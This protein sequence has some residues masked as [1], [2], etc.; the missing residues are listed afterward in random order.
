MKSLFDK[1]PAAPTLF[2]IG[3][4]YLLGLIGFRGVDRA[5]VEL[6][7]RVRTA[8]DHLM[9]GA[10]GELFASPH[11]L[12]DVLGIPLAALGSLELWGFGIVASIAVALCLPAVWKMARAVSGRLGAIFAV[13]FF[14]G[15]P[16]VTAAA[17]TVGESAI[18]LVLWCWLLRFSVRS[19][20]TRLST[21]LLVGLAVALT[22]SWAPALLWLVVWLV[23]YIAARGFSHPE[24]RVDAEGLIDP[25]TIPL[26]LILAPLAAVVVPSLLFL[27]ADGD[28]GAGWTRFLEHA[29]F[30]DWAVIEY[31]GEVFEEGRP[32]LLIGVSWLAFET[33]PV[34][35][36]TAMA[37]LILPATERFGLFVERPDRTR[38]FEFP[39]SLCVA[40][41]IFLLLLP[42]ALRTRSIGGVQTLLLAAPILAILAGALAATIVRSVADYVEAHDFSAPIR[43]TTLG[44]LTGLLLAPGLVE[45][46][47]VHPYEGSYYNLFSNSIA[48]AVDHGHP[49]IRDDAL[50]RSV[51]RE[52]AD[53]AGDRALYTDR[54]RDH[55]ETYLHTDHLTLTHLAESPDEADAHFYARGAEPDVD[56]D[57]RFTWGMEGVALYYLDLNGVE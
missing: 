35:L 20:H 10:I 28:I 50:P 8:N 41:L 37:A 30:G 11:P 48:G 46:V 18:V 9:E 14:L 42:W 16:A 44:L 43:H 25:T 24:K 5:G 38:D 55:F 13:G 53:R 15:M 36:V 23:V 7:D 45:T 56:A 2:A 19:H 39:R 40:T 27:V 4:V 49:P 6:L 31:G 54:W 33:P 51:A 47:L 22:L 57:R 34:V 52:A 26:P 32:S 12:V 1:L 3:L 29:F 17:T 21:A